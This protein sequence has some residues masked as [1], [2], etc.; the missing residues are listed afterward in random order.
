MAKKKPGK[1]RLSD[2]TKQKIKDNFDSIDPKD[3]SK[4][5]L[6]YYWVVKGTK[7]AQAKREAIERQYITVDGERYYGKVAAI[8]KGLASEAGEK[9]S[10]H[11][12]KHKSFIK[13]VIKENYDRNP[14]HIDNIVELIEKSR[15]KTVWI[16]TGDGRVEMSKQ[17]AIAQLVLFNNFVKT[18]STI[19]DMT[20][21]RK[22]RFDGTLEI[23]IPLYESYG[24]EDFD[25][26]D[27]EDL[28]D[29]FDIFFIDSPKGK[30][31]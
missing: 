2:K 17:D 10:D 22:V 24:D 6:R 4:N 20:I 12:E 23:E 9:V 28:L 11:I 29:D 25:Q 1:I 7:A 15:K 5:K 27:I 3:L 31:K 14:K 30:K 13:N 19:V 26:G 16:N 18:N 21:Q 8:I